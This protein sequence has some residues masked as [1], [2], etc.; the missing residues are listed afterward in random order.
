M[1]RCPDCRKIL[2]ILSP[3]AGA[4]SPGGATVMPEAGMNA[5]PA[6]DIVRCWHGATDRWQGNEDSSIC[7]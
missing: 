6:F 7:R 1:Y 4:S 5:V 2:L 3:T